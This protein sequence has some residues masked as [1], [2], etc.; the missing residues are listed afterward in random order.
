MNPQWNGKLR[1]TENIATVL[2][3]RETERHSCEWLEPSD[4]Q[5]GMILRY[6][7]NI[8]P[9]AGTVPVNSL[10]TAGTC[11]IR[12][13]IGT[14]PNGVDGVRCAGGIAGWYI[15]ALLKRPLYIPP[16]L[17]PRTPN[18]TPCCC[19]VLVHLVEL[20]S[21]PL[22]YVFSRAAKARSEPYVCVPCGEERWR[23]VCFFSRVLVLLLVFLVARVSCAVVYVDRVLLLSLSRSGY[24]F[25]VK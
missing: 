24:T 25:S 11:H 12:T 7:R 8:G 19:F 9:V 14:T 13:S 5:R 23:F 6:Y 2:L 15:P 4:E 16:R 3:V 21:P 22:F 17:R 18:P 10:G 20:F 1:Y